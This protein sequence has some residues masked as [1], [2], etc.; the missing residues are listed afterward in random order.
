[1]DKQLNNEKV[2]KVTGEEIEAALALRLVGQPWRT[3]LLILG[4]TAVG[5]GTLGMFLP[6]LPT[7]PFLLLAAACFSRSSAS[8]QHWLFHHKYLGTYLQN[9]LLRKG[10]TKRQLTVALTTL[11]IS[12]GIAILFIPHILVSILLV[13]IAGLVSVH[14]LRLRRLA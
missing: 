10:I 13:I 5:L 7:V 8:L 2:T 3:V 11:W 14:L 1:M 12:M 6:L 4:C 9:Y